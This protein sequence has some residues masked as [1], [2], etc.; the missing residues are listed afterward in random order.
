MK[1]NQGKCQVLHLGRN[2]PRH[3]YMPVADWLGSSFAEKDEGVL[4]DTRLDM[5]Q[6]CALPA[7]AANS[8]LG[9][10]R[11]SVISRPRDVT[12]PW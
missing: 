10:I 2:N 1:F 4:V 3:Q 11:Q 5:S 9:C 6:Q 8:T 12:Q 7:K